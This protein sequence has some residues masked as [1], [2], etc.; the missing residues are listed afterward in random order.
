MTQNGSSEYYITSVEHQQFL[1]D[2]KDNGVLPPYP[3]FTIT[4]REGVNT[5]T[6]KVNGNTIRNLD[7]CVSSFEDRHTEEW[8][9]TFREAHRPYTVERK[10]EGGLAWTAPWLEPK[11][12]NPLQILCEPLIGNLSDPPQ[13]DPAHLFKF[14]LAK[15]VK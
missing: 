10:G 7:N 12:P 13:F 5:Y 8:I 3:I 4:K 15:R 11:K 1:S 9:I 6:I 2:A 14:E